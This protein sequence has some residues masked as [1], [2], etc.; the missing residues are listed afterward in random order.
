[1]IILLSNKFINSIAINIKKI[2]V[3]KIDVKI[4]FNLTKQDYENDNLYII[5]TI[6]KN[7][8]LPKKYI[9]YQIEQINSPL[10]KY[11]QMVNSEYIW[12][13][14]MFNTLFYEK[15]INLNKV[16]YCP[17]P[18]Y[19]NNYKNSIIKYDLLF[20][21][22]LNYRRKQ[23][24]LKINN[25]YK[26]K[27]ISNVYGNDLYDYISK[28][29]IIINLHFYND[30]FLET[31]RINEI[32]NYDKIII[33]ELPHKYDYQNKLLYS[34]IVIFFEIINKNMSNINNL[35]ELIDYYLIP[36]NYNNFISKLN[37]NK[38]KLQNITTN[39]FFQNIN[40]IF[41]SD[42]K[43]RYYPNNNLFQ[44]IKYSN[45]LL[46]YKFI[47][48]KIEKI[49]Y[50]DN[51][52]N[53]DINFYKYINKINL[54]F[55]STLKHIS[56]YSIEN[57]LIYHPTQITNLYPDVKITVIKKNFYIGDIE[58]KEYVKKNIYKLTFNNFMEDFFEIKESNISDDKILILV[59]IGNEHIGIKLLEK[60][61]NYKNKFIIGVCFNSYN[62]YLKLKHIILV[63]FNNY[64]IGISKNYGNDII[65][66][67]QLYWYLNKNIKFENI[68]K[69]HTKSDFIWFNDLNDFIF[70]N[71]L[72]I[73]DNYNC[74][75]NC[76]CIGHPDYYLNIYDIKSFE[77]ET[78]KKLKIKYSDKINKE[79]F[80]KGC[81]FYCKKDIFDK[82]INFIQNNN[83]RQYFTN[84]LYDSNIINIKNSPIHW[85]ERLFGII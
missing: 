54:D 29:K 5:L 82:V 19:N 13:L 39:I 22:N 73:F 76:N 43:L 53:I 64:C 60:I 4:I 8:K 34:D 40:M 38:K 44:Y 66:S 51:C 62:I 68:I 21:G 12:E 15:N 41:E 25:K 33:S 45:K 16:Y 55:K 84:N 10:V 78:L 63:N 48:I 17:L 61:I 37:K 46:E 69:T 28:S 32:L 80:V 59:F 3:N 42:N 85:L 65:P 49:I 27:I 77:N 67:L 70:S 24:L 20:Y 6:I 50:Y 36:E 79:Y 23:I 75:C 57:G 11:D 74:N 58:L 14:S 83:Y 52:F 18:F 26:I 30:A 56:S 71:N 81:I 2:L 9:Y 35:F 7:I 31:C 47:L 1:M 72:D